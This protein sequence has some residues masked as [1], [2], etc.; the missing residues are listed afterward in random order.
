VV[1][2]AADN[3]AEIAVLANPGVHLWVAVRQGALYQDGRVVCFARKVCRFDTSPLQRQRYA[4]I[5]PVRIVRICSNGVDCSPHGG[6]PVV[7]CAFSARTRQT[8]C[9]AKNTLLTQ[10]L[11]G[12]SQR[13]AVRRAFGSQKSEK[14]LAILHHF[15]R[16]GYASDLGH[17]AH[18]CDNTLVHC[19]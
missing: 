17:A 19:S 16:Q 4:S 13:F 6:S 5:T 11:A 15:S 14:R 7:S 3:Q 2:A 1:K 18:L 8:I 10:S 12:L 9:G